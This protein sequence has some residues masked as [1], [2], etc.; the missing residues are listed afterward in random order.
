MIETGQQLLNAGNDWGQ[1]LRALAAVA[2]AGL[3]L[4]PAAVAAFR[5]AT[6]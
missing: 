2:V 5:A 3:V 6:R 4:V 1:D